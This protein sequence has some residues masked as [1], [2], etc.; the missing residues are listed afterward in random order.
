[1]P[2]R[3]KVLYEV[4]LSHKKR[5]ARLAITGRSDQRFHMG[6][7]ALQGSTSCI[8]QT[9]LRPRN[10]ALEELGAANVPGLFRFT[11][12]TNVV[13]SVPAQCRDFV[14]SLE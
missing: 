14:S 5:G 6:E 1:M 12:E 9:V 4:K 8:G 2:D 7:I 10:A 13:E 11:N 3:A